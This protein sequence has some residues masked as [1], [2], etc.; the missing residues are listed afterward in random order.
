MFFNDSPN[1]NMWLGF[2]FLIENGGIKSFHTG[3]CKK[4]TFLKEIV[5]SYKLK[6]HTWRTILTFIK[7]YFEYFPI[8]YKNTTKHDFPSPS[9]CRKQGNTV[10]ILVESGP[11][12]DLGA[13][14]KIL[15]ITRKSQKYSY[16]EKKHKLR[17]LQIAFTR[18]VSRVGRPTT[19]FYIM[20]SIYSRAV[21]P[22][23]V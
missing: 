12:R 9:Y 18:A 20:I 4:T 15:K 14:I 3:F 10:A 23:H 7:Q 17:R 16:F 1:E 21:G 6:Y 5:F 11:N 13:D 2:G 19:G 22:P 8:I